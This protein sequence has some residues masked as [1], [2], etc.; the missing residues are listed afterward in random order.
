MAQ[1]ALD[2]SNDINYDPANAAALELPSDVDP[3]TR[4][5]HPDN[6]DSMLDAPGVL[7]ESREYLQANQEMVVERWLAWLAQ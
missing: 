5:T 7:P 2:L 1:A 6:W 4:A 3:T